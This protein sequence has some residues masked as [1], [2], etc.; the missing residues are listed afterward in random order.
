MRSSPAPTLAPASGGSSPPGSPRG[1]APGAPVTSCLN[2]VPLLMG[3]LF[4]S[5]SAYLS[6]VFLVSDARR[7]DTPGL[8][9]YF[10]VRALATGLFAGAVA[11]AGIFVLR[12]DAHHLFE[13][14]VHDGL[15]LAIISAL[16]GLGVLVLL[17]RGA[18][19]AARPLA[20]GA[21]AAVVWSWGVAQ[22]P[23]LLPQTLTI[24]AGA[25]PDATLTGILIVFGVAVLLVVPSIALLFSLVQRNLVEEGARPK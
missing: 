25:A 18:P 19:R 23:Y 1:N 6:A 14:L 9:R 5:T 4:V 17:R 12:A 8:E 10:K 15:P 11:F 24:N 21:V 22:Y 16:S 20:V 13:G 3:A 2:A 7:A